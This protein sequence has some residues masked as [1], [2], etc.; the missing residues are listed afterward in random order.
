[1]II[2]PDF[3]HASFDVRKQ[4]TK[5]LDQ[6]SYWEM[7]ETV[8][9]HEPNV[10]LVPGQF[11]YMN[12]SDKVNRYGRSIGTPNKYATGGH[13]WYMTTRFDLWLTLPC[14][15]H[16]YHGVLITGGINTC[17][18]ARRTRKPNRHL[19]TALDTLLAGEPFKRV[20]PSN[21]QPTFEQHCYPNVFLMRGKP[22]GEMLVT[23]TTSGA[24]VFA[25]DL[26]TLL[27]NRLAA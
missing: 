26:G 20:L 22:F 7:P 16:E 25:K 12:H 14:A 27:A 13:N 23:N 24:W 5:R 8:S 4:H 17:L 21:F 11:H 19:R 6:K 3:V 15:L 2:N 9:I 1:M 18:K 10:R